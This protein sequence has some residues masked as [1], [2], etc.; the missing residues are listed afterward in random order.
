MT[1]QQRHVLITGATSGIGRGLAE[2]YAKQGATVGVIARRAD[3]LE[4][5]AEGHPTMIPL[6]ADVTDGPAME[7]VISRFALEA[8]GLDLVYANAG[9]GQSNAEQAWDTDRARAITEINILGT[10]NT[11]TP[12]I[13]IMIEQNHGR[14]I[15]ISSLAGH[16]PL[17]CSAV[18]GSSKAWMVF[19]LRSLA[20]DLAQY[21]I[22]CTVVMP[23]HVSTAMVDGESNVG[24]LTP[25]AQR[26]AALIAQRVARGE[27]TIRFPKR[28]SILTRLAGWT[29]A[30]MRANAQRKRLEK[31]QAIR[32]ETSHARQ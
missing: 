28:M 18:Y 30:G 27:T 25:Q 6:P 4:Q 15:G 14:L 19:Y 11:I 22:H 8:G 23:G 3:I 26:A 21:N 31:R 24:L 16:T 10:V 13:P 9:I 2:H 17:P 29:P 12:A 32:G 7:Q 1:N 5:M 20:M